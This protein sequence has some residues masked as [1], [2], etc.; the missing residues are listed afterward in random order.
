MSSIARSWRCAISKSCPT[1]RLPKSWASNRRRRAFAMCVPS[2][3]SKRFCRTCQVLTTEPV[4]ADEPTSGAEHDREPVELLAAEFVDRHRSGE[5]P[6]ID[7]YTRQ[8][9]DLADEI[10]DLFPTIA[11]LE[12]LRLS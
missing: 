5:C 12:E 4:V 9:P 11:K 6:Q 3:D 7:E 8:H 1:A 10:R 2:S